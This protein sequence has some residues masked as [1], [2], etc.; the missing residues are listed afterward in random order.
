MSNEIATFVPVTDMVAA[1]IDDKAFKTQASD[2]RFLPYLGISAGTS[3]AVADGLIGVGKWFLTKRKKDIID[4]GSEF[5]GFILGMR[6]KALNLNGDK[7][8]AYFDHTSPEFLDV[9]QK[10]KTMPSDSGYLAG[11]D[12]LIYIPGPLDLF[13]TYHMASKTAK[14]EAGML[15]QLLGKPATFKLTQLQNPK[16]QKWF[17][18]VVTVCSVDLQGPS[19]DEY[20]AVLEAFKNPPKV[21]VESVTE[22]EKANTGREV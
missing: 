13:V 3:T 11:A 18:P 20:L 17:G 12:F 19:R 8:V 1:G 15:K 10:A 4:L 16:G 14:N 22:E 21:Q 2:N 9:A 7:P 6:L 5:R